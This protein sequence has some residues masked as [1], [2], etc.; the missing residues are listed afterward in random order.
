MDALKV[1]LSAVGSVVAL[2]ILTKLIGYKQMAQLSMFDYIVGISIGS[3]AAEM[4]TSLEG[5]VWQPLLAM[6]VYA[7]M[8]IIISTVNF[9][10]IK[11]RNFLEGKPLILFQDGELYKRNLKKCK[12]DIGEFLT[13]CRNSG[14]FNLSDIHTALLETNGKISFL[15]VSSQRP[16]IPADFNIF[17][18]QERPCANVV[19]DGNI[20]DEN[21]INM[22]KNRNWLKK[23]LS[24]QGIADASKVFLATCDANGN[25]SVYIKIENDKTKD[26][27]E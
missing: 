11:A 25:L 4:A 22:G 26:I 27:F 13:Q 3:I 14:Y 23:Q 17:P 2:F 20:M 19:L 18:E 5:N 15:P 21:L 16:A 8:D 24:N 7:I 6:A 10:S 1:F 9:K 12:M